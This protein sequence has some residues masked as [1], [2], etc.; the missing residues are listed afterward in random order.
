[1]TGPEKERKYWIWF[2]VL[3][4]LLGV[5]VLFLF[6]WTGSTRGAVDDPYRAVPVDA[7]MMTETDDLPQV[8]H[9]LSSSSAV[10]AD[11]SKVPDIA[12]V[13]RYFSLADSL[14]G[15]SRELYRLFRGGPL[16]ISFH[17]A[18]RQDADLLAVVLLPAGYG[19][20]GVAG[21][22]GTVSR[23]APLREYNHVKIYS[24]LF[25]REKNPLYFAVT[26]GL[27]L[28]SPD[29]ILLE[30]SIR[31]SEAG[32]SLLQDRSFVRLRKTA[33][34]NEVMNLYLRGDRMPFFLRRWLQAD[35][36]R[37]LSAMMPAGGWV[38]L[39]LSSAG[40]SLL[41]NG[42][43]I[44][45]DST[46][47][48]ADLLTGC[49]PEEA[50]IFEVIPT[51]AVSATVLTFG[52]AQRYLGQLNRYR[53][54]K[55]L[56]RGDLPARFRE[57]TGRDVGEVFS[58]FLTRQAAL[59]ELSVRNETPAN[60]TFVVSAV[61]S[62]MAARRETEKILG[63]YAKKKNLALSSLRTTVSFDRETKMEVYHFPFAGVPQYLF[64]GFTGDHPYRYMMITD[65]YILWGNSVRAVSRYLRFN[66]LQQ[67]LSHDPA[68]REFTDGMASRSNLFYFLRLPD[69]GRII[70]KH[71]SSSFA[72]SYKAYSKAGI[73]LR[74]IGYEAI[75]QNG[76]IYNNIFLHY[77]ERTEERAVTV[78]ESLLDTLFDYKPQLVVNHRTGQKEIFLQ[79]AANRLYL[80]NASG[81]ILW[82]VPV[83]ER[84]LG[85][86]YQ[87]DFYRNGK[88]QLLF[89]TRHYL[90]LVDRNGNFVERFPVSLRSAASGPLALFDYDHNRKYRIFIPGEDKRVYV[91][92]Q[93]GNLVPGWQIPR[94]ESVV[95]GPV[96]H[97]VRSGRDYIVFTDTMNLYILDRKGHVRVSVPENI[98]R[99]PHQNIF[100]APRPGGGEPS[101]V[102]N[103]IGGEVCFV[104]LRG[105]V[106]RLRFADVP[107]DAWF[108]YEDLDGNGRREFLFL[109]DD[110][111][112]VMK[113]PDKEFF[114][115]Q[116]EEGAA[117]YAPV[118]YT[119]SERDKKTGIVDAT[120]GNIYLVNNNG[121]L[122]EGFPMR[123]RTQ[124][125]IGRLGAAAGHF[126]L[127]VGGD[128]NFLYNYSVK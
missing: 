90:Y 110:K 122:Y 23:V 26:K 117:S 84:I 25:S 39:D 24:A 40:R 126:N 109:Y 76:M 22:L 114:T 51:A 116:I 61:K 12:G 77:Q 124:F 71:F 65:H 73:N 43:M 89:N 106:T 19:G 8:V 108:L 113:A 80:I 72:A 36:F 112:Q 52:D 27:L 11:L 45:G 102:V 127:I 78:W 68:F 87:I 30:K 97:F 62:G 57:V 56:R 92:D 14:F 83:R 103:T 53:R 70:D 17:N 55:G 104:S 5:F 3:L 59:V 13:T 31:Q 35:L 34:R 32:R 21:V 107:D 69:A 15:V 75:A 37:R 20:K 46:S 4:V 28:M 38:E 85:Q 29:R 96:K 66:I 63:E 74:Y 60:N 123:G 48:L 81:R 120:H 50:D 111:L 88:L 95:R 86:A 93:R 121:K 98:V 101:F 100:L 82:K 54:H 119:F 128:D 1:M 9:L 91:Y 99:P 105:K 125:S 79:D 44:T 7:F 49:E 33:G 42:F 115:F 47:Y 18:G 10:W 2:G 58:S 94:C 16:V 41:L 67:T 118:I 64:G 6:R